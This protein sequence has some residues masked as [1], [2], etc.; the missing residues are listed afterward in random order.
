MR[1][2]ICGIIIDYERNNIYVLFIAIL[3]EGIK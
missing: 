1:T 2:H 3:V